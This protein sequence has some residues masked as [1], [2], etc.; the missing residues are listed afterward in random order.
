MKIEP[1]EQKPEEGKVTA[2]SKS[3]REQTLKRANESL[4]KWESLV[5]SFLSDS[6][7]RAKVPTATQVE[8]K[9][10]QM[11][12]VLK[13]ETSLG[14]RTKRGDDISQVGPVLRKVRTAVRQMESLKAVSGAMEAEGGES[15]SEESEEGEGVPKIKVLKASPEEKLKKL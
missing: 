6:E 5:N 12:G 4:A 8:K 15:D 13:K 2:M 3:T 9:I 10:E 7:K 14:T 1:G 11:Q